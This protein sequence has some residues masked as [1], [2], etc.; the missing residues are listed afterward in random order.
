M[1]QEHA[2]P[3]EGEWDL[4]LDQVADNWFGCV[5]EA[6][7]SSRYSSMIILNRAS[8]PP[9]LVGRLWCPWAET[10]SGGG[11][12]WRGNGR[13]LRVAVMYSDTAWNGKT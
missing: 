7:A 5:F 2:L 11:Q 9:L 6:I 4:D 1:S 8:A 10:G 13:G 12:R 3:E